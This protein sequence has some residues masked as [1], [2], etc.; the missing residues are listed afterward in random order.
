MG[1]FFEEAKADAVKFFSSGCSSTL[2]SSSIL[3]R[4]ST[5]YAWNDTTSGAFMD[6][7]A[8][9]LVYKEYQHSLKKYKKKYESNDTKAKEK[10]RGNTQAWFQP[11][12]NR[13]MSFARKDKRQSRSMHD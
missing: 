8:E 4:A 11:V 5:I 7:M 13:A 1:D 9:E 6:L 10:R 2:T 12:A 3:H